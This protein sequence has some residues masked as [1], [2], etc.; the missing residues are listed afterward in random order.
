MVRNYKTAPDFYQITK[1]LDLNS[2]ASGGR[3]GRKECPER[4]GSPPEFERD[5]QTTGV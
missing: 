3:V 5:T 4:E 2:P 1:Q